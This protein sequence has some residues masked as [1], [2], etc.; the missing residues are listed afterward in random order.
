MK[1]CGTPSPQACSMWPA[2]SAIPAL[3]QRLAGKLA[4]IEAG[5]ARPAATCSSIFPPSPASTRAVAQGLGAAGLGKGDGWR[6][7]V[8]EK[9][10]GHDLASARE[11]SDR[12]HEV[13]DESDVYRIDHYLGKE[14]VQNILAFRFGNGIFEPLWNR[15]YVNHVQITGGGIH[16]RRGPRR[17]LPGS[18][19]AGGHDPEPPAAGDGHHRHGADRQLPRRLRARRALQAAALHPAHDARRDPA[20]RRGRASTGRRASAARMCRASARNRASTRSRRPTPTPPSPSLSK[21]GA[22]PA[23]RSTCAPA[24]GCPS[25]SPKSPS[26]S[27]PA[28][29]AIFD[30]DGRRGPARPTC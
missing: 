6:R 9:P 17:L 4:E 7:L 12:L 28:P 14:T 15:R 23:C 22:G 20:Q 21:T 10:F 1:T 11:L 3:Y 5:R 29:L 25:A 26:S 8:V 24:S 30:G 13:F 16:R 2:T 27:T 18:R 19:R